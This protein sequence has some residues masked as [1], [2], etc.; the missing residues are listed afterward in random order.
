MCRSCAEGGR[1]CP[2]TQRTLRN[3][4]AAASRYYQRGK[5]RRKIAELADA[6]IPAV[7]DQQ[8]PAGY[9]Q[10]ANDQPLD[11]SGANRELKNSRSILPDKPEGAVWT[12][13]GRANS[14][15]TINTA[16][17]DWSAR[18]DYD[19]GNGSFAEIQPQPG[20]VI[21]LVETPQDAQNLMDTYGSTSPDGVQSFD[22]QGM[23]NDGIDAV[24]VNEDMASGGAAYAREGEDAHA[25][26]NFDDWDTSSTV[27]L[28]T[29]RCAVGESYEA[30]TSAAER[31]QEDSETEG[32]TDE[33]GPYNE[34]ARP[35]METAWDRVPNRFKTDMVKPEPATQSTLSGIA[36]EGSG[37]YKFGQGQKG[38]KVPQTMDILDLA[39]TLMAGASPRRRKKK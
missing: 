23:R 36:P 18:N 11:L 32:H 26:A 35:D 4:R 9:H 33:G 13:P 5:A 28:S 22:W 37:P 10:L 20:S 12:S 14:D 1:R 21:V 7:G 29:D 24:H 15:G 31:Q 39:T 27:W 38:V 30:E 19:N 17:A 34:P 8:M 2:T 6:G 16:W 25:A 3:G